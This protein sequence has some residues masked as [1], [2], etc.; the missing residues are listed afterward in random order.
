MSKKSV[1]LVTFDG[2]YLYASIFYSGLGLLVFGLVSA[3]PWIVPGQPT[4]ASLVCKSPEYDFGE[5]VRTDSP[6]HTFV[7]ENRGKQPVSILR[8]MPGCSAC[9]RIVDY[10]QTPIPPGEKGFVTLQLLAELIETDASS[11]VLVRSD[12]PV[13][14]AFLL[15]LKAT[16]LPDNAEKNAE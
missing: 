5:I 16:I 9:I 10:P 3:V 15:T 13:S 1:A 4:R 12:D 11:Q 7:L 14:P 2:N 8:V 6:K